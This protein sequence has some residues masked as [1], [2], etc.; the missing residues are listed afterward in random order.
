VNLIQVD[1]VSP[2]ASQTVLALRDDP[3]A[4]VALRVGVVAHLAVD[5][6]R[7][8]HTRPVKRGEGL[9]DDDFGLALGVDVGG[10][11]EVNAGVER[12]V[13]D[14]D[15]IVVIGISPGP[16]HHGPEAQWAD[17]DAGTTK[18]TKFHGATLEP[19]DVNETRTKRVKLSLETK[20]RE[21]HFGIESKMGRVVG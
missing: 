11:D 19:H 17:F 14:A 6:G 8:D 9:T 2:E 5:F 18:V 15:R 4:R 3:P 20:I 10:V 7:Q 1:V 12:A 21:M 16:E 13:D